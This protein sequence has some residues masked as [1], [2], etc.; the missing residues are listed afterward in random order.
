MQKTNRETI[1]VCIRMR[2]I[3]KPYEDEE[4]WAIDKSSNTIYSTGNPY[5]FSA[6]LLDTSN[7]SLNSLKERDIRRRY[8]ET[9]GPQSFSFDVVFDQDSTSQQ[10][11]TKVCRPIVQSVM[12]GYNGTVFMYGQTTSGKT[13]TML[14]VPELPG[15]LPCAIKDIFQ[16]IA[17]DIDHEYSVWVSYLEIYNEQINDLLMPGSNNL[18]IKEDPK[19]GV[20]IQGVKRQQ[21]WTFDQVI[22]LMNY[23]EE[24]RS[25]RGTSIHEHSSRS[26]TIFQVFIESTS[27]ADSGTGDGRLRFGC[28]NLVDLAGS[29][30]LSEFEVRQPDLLGET[31][32]I[33]KSLFV[34]AL[35]ISKLAEG[36]SQ[37]IPYRD[38]KLTRI[39]SMALGGNSLTAVICTLSPAAMNFQQTISTLRFAMSAKTV[40]NVP[41]VNELLDDTAA[42]QEYRAE[43][44]RLRENLKKAQEDSQKLEK[45]NMNLAKQVE[46]YEFNVR[47]TESALEEIRQN[48]D[49][50]RKRIEEIESNYQIQQTDHDLQKNDLIERYQKLLEKYQEELKARKDT[51][52]DLEKLKRSSVS[53]MRS[54]ALPEE[55]SNKR[56]VRQ[57]DSQSH[58]IPKYPP[59]NTF[60][61]NLLFQL[62]SISA[63]EETKGNWL[64]MTKKI[65]EQYKND[66][67]NLQIHYKRKLENI[68]K[69]CMP[70]VYSNIRD[71]EPE[72]YIGRENKSMV[73]ELI[74]KG[75][76]FDD[77]RVDFSL[78]L[79]EFLRSASESEDLAEVMISKLKEHHDDL[80]RKIDYRFEE[81]RSLLEVY[82]REKVS[83]PEQD[84]ASITELT[85]QHSSLLKRLRNLYES[86]LQELEMSYVESLKIFDDFISGSKEESEDMIDEVVEMRIEEQDSEAES[87]RSTPTAPYKIKVTPEPELSA[88][89][90]KIPIRGFRGALWGSGK[91]GRCGIGSEESVSTPRMILKDSE[92]RFTELVCGYH[93]SAGI[94]VQGALYTWGRGIFGQL[95]HGNNESYAVPMRVSS[96]DKF[97]VLQVACGWQH[98]I[99]LTTSGK[100]FSWGYG[101]DGQLGHGDNEDCLYPVEI[102]SLQ[103]V[104]INFIA[105]GHSHSGCLGEGKLYMWGCN[106]DARLFASSDESQYS[107]IRISIPGRGKYLGLGVSHSALILED[108]SL[109]TAGTG[110]DGQLGYE[111]EE[112]SEIHKVEGFSISRRAI[113]VS[114]GDCYTLVLDSK[115]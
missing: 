29:E 4:I 110:S 106:P 37:H 112:Y 86:T 32:H 99:A 55:T 5:S 53:T 40:Q 44:I 88:K 14:G 3:L 91:D 10:I 82:F 96:L 35:V 47:K 20:V 74:N 25:Y 64:E 51:E 90:V 45:Q 76:I 13:Y 104:I 103:N 8:A 69:E 75:E 92:I 81:A 57:E 58:F 63:S 2:P 7:V 21:V 107:P 83:S 17:R 113:Q 66:L 114:C 80:V 27:K 102:E 33:N 72:K 41:E 73:P 48:Q 93:H 71:E 77:I 9:Y 19:H 54:L 101:D 98:T 42:I 18:K 23:G 34:L 60:I 50:E 105:C 59:E 46:D 89:S 109:Y 78:V 61:D 43:I 115:L 68:V 62:D 28:L 38:S 67:E 52:R 94:T 87:S 6:T 100:V 111:C 39:L 85:S 70:R 95:G 16:A 56:Q 108:G 84:P 97:S 12:S 22:I 15:I 30:R 1:K 49:R 24:H 26:H 11:Y 79:D 36:K 31:G 65:A